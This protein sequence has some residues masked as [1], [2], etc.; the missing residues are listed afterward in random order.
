MPFLQFGAPWIDA[1]LLAARLNKLNLAGIQFEATSFTPIGS[2]YEGQKCYGARISATQRGVLEPYW[3][4]ILIVNEIHHTYPDDFEW[5]AGHFDNLC[6]SATVR[7]AITARSSLEKL[8]ESW[9]APLKS[10]LQIRKRYLL[11]PK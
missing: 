11:Y 4:G 5:R 3:T 6:G 9:Q 10:F 7:S 1:E 2:K 8:K